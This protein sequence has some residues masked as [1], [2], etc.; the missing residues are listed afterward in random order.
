MMS[1]HS[2]AI[3][4]TVVWVL[5]LASCGGPPPEGPPPTLIADPAG[6]GNALPGAGMSDFDRGVAFVE[7]KAYEQAIEYFD[8]AL[9]ANPQHAK[10]EYYRAVARERLGQLPEA[11]QG[12][13]RSLELDPTLVDAA[14]NLA[15]LYLDEGGDPPRK[16]D[17][18]KAIALLRKAA[19]AVPDD[20]GVQENLGYAYRLKKDIAK[21]SSY[22]DKALQLGGG[23]RT[24][25]A[26]GDM[27]YDA[28]QCAPA[29]KQLE[30]ALP[31][32]QADLQVLTTIGD[33]LRHCEA[34]PACVKA[35][36]G[37]IALS[38]KDPRLHVSR[39]LCHHGAKNEAQA[40][41]D[42]QAALDQNPKHAAAYYF[43]GMSWRE[44]NN[45]LKAGKAFEQAI[46]LDP[47][48][49]IGKKARAAVDEMV[50]GKKR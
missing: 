5:G 42:Y 13:E 44:E 50:G 7:K 36:D 16:P 29:A 14:V 28:K 15:A 4:W 11:I 10:A 6:S 19:E 1:M 3:P 32:Y 38:E 25:F 45:K 22:Y 31:G 8:K 18:D 17:P 20:P 48:G 34:W 12:Y 41:Q 39:G 37:A 21:A 33:L 27:L 40:R 35:F 24:H 47:T 49:P 9:E 26:Y 30:L 2:G 23:P 43:M 46:K